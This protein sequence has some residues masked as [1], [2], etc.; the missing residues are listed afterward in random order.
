MVGLCSLLLDAHWAAGTFKLDRAF[1]LS[2]RTR[3]HKAGHLAILGDNERGQHVSE[4]ISLEIFSIT[5][6]KPSRLNVDTSLLR[7]NG[8][9]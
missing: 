3:F 9:T 1:T 2:W 8:T 6:R 4:L 5:G 7:L